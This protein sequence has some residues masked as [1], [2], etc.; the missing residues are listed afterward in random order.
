MVVVVVMLVLVA[1]LT[2]FD[3]SGPMGVHVDMTTPGDEVLTVFL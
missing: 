3:V 1:V 2:S